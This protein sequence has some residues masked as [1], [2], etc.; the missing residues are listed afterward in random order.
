MVVGADASTAVAGLLRSRRAA[1]VQAVL[2]VGLVAGRD[3]L[4]GVSGVLLLAC[5]AA[6]HLVLL[7]LARRAADGLESDP[8]GVA[9]ADVVRL[10]LGLG[11]I[12]DRSAPGTG[13]IATLG[14]AA[15]SQICC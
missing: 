13:A 6:A 10:E 14:G 9:A 5:G 15:D 7:D 1:L 3:A 2:P 12:E 4:V 11:A 8:A